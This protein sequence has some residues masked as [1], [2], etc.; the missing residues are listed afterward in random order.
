MKAF[1]TSSD[2]GVVIRLRAEGGGIVGDA[3]VDLHKGETFY[4]LSY[5]DLKNGGSGEIL[6]EDGKA[7]LIAAKPSV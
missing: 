1:Y 4:G 5:V 7:T 2:G 6:I 3:I